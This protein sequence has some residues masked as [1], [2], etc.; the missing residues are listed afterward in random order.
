MKEKAGWMVF[1]ITK[2]KGK[3]LERMEKERLVEIGVK[4]RG[5]E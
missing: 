5:I 1:G 3:E 2:K 4:K